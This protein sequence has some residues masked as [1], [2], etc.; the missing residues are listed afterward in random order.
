[1]DARALPEVINRLLPIA[2]LLTV[3]IDEARAFLGC[4]V[5]SLSDARDAARALARRGARAVLV[6]GGHLRGPLATDVLLIDGNVVELRA[7]RL[8]GGPVH[9]T[10][11][12]LAS[13]VAGRLARIL[14]D[15]LPDGRV[16][17]SAVR[18]AKRIHH[19]AFANAVRVGPGMRVMMP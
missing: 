3:N 2:T 16:L 1:M 4:Q 18:W 12:T 6:K 15:G 10:G 13:L 14:E 5:R 19:A 17:L 11:C 7:T 8:S 9:G